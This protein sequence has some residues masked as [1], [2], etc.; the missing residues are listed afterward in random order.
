[1][2][3]G[4]GHRVLGKIAEGKITAPVSGP[5]KQDNEKADDRVWFW[6]SIPLMDS[7]SQIYITKYPF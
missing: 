5:S 4:D 7:V 2:I 3:R 1:M 6:H